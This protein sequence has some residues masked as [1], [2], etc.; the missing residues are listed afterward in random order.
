MTDIESTSADV[1]SEAVNRL[2]EIQL[3]ASRVQNQKRALVCLDERRQKLREAERILQKSKIQGPNTWVCLGPTT[4]IQFPTTMAAGFLA[5]DR[6]VVE[7]TLSETQADIHK[8]VDD[9]L[10]AE[11]NKTLK[12]RG[13]DLNSILKTIEE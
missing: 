4:F 9:L 2:C 7:D 3:S 10:Q 11:G 13:F 6:K 1:V 12:E 8:S 5:K